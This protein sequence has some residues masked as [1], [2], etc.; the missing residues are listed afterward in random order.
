MNSLPISVSF[1][2]PAF[3]WLLFLLPLFLVLGW[4]AR[5]APD[6][7]QRWLGVTVRLLVL[8]GLILGLAGAQIERPADLI[9]T[10]FVLDISDSVTG[11]ERARAEAFIR[12][13]LAQKPE[14][15]QAAVILFGGDA[16]VERLPRPEPALP[17]LTSTPLKNATDIEEALRLALALLPNEGGRRLVL[18]SDGQETQ[19]EARRLLDL[20]AARQVEISLYPLGQTT[21]AGPPEVLVEQVTAPSQAR[22]GQTVP[23]DVVVTASRATEAT[24]RLL[25]DGSPVESRAVRLV[26]GQNRF[27]FNLPL[28]ETGFHRFRVEIEAPAD[29]RLQNN[30]GAAFTTVYGPPQVLLVEGQPGEGTALKSALD[31]AGI[32]SS[33]T[34]PASLPASLP[35]LAAYDA[36][37][38]LNVPAPALPNATQEMLAGFVRDLGRGLVMVGGPEGYGAGGYLRSPLEKALPVDME[39]RSRSRE[40]NIALVLAVDKSGSM[41]ACHCDNPDLRQSYTRAPS[42][43]PKIDIAKEAIFQAAAVLGNLDYLGVVSFDDS[44]HWE[45]EPSPGVSSNDLEA[46]IGAIP[47][48]GQTNIYAGLVAAEES[49]A[50]LP[51]RLKHII[52]LTDGWSHSGAYDALTARLAE[53]GITLSVVAAGGG[54]AEYLADLARKGGGQYYPAATMSEVPQIFL[55]ETVRAVGDYVIEEPFLPV[56]VTGGAGEEPAS[57]ILRGLDLAAAPPL[58]GY[59]GTTPKTAARLALLTPRGDPLLATWQYG[60]GRSAAW[61]ADLSG[62]WAKNWLTWADFAHFA[63]QLVTWTLPRPGDEQLD[64]RIVVN[65]GQATLEAAMSGAGQTAPPAQITAKLLTPAGESLETEL[66]PSGAN[67]YE[68]AVPLPGEGVYLAQVTAYAQDSETQTPLASQTTGLV[69]PYSA[70]YGALTADPALLA[71]LATATGGQMLNDPAQAFAHNLAVGRQSYPIWPGLLLLTALLFPFDVALRRLRLGRRE[72]EQVRVWLRARLP[73]PRLAPAA[74]LEPATPSVQAFRQ[75]RERAQRPTATPPPAGPSRPAPPVVRP[76]EPPPAASP[77]SVSPPASPADGD[78]LA[79]LRA[80]KKRARH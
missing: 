66:R 40:P 38:L 16:L 18:L 65:S 42:G 19:G 48:N 36:V 8:L 47:A 39:V 46:A 59:N 17:T 56:P 75:A 41:G 9:T 53:Q 74:P 79:R 7:R 60:L 30:W 58:L 77:P 45:L 55:K 57:P 70:E 43:L 62:R 13:A 71:D 20:A 14:E 23:L 72:W 21:E 63:G 24:L 26:Q 1:L 15:D 5:H 61:T 76:V 11:E 34:Q 78:T 68:A 54:S 6:R 10:V 35:D 2:Y 73:G 4:P 12:A 44:A 29:G 28:T 52:L 64:L 49:L 33:L 51:A 67:R 22:Q 32:K 27:A 31:A 80:A 37:I 69:A 3:L 25:A 50:A